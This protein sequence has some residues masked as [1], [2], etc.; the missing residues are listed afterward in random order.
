VNLYDLLCNSQWL[1]VAWGH[2]STNAGS[3]TAGVDHETMTTFNEPPDQKL[4]ALREQRKAGTFEPMPVRRVYIPKA[5]GKQRPL[6]IP[7]IADRIVQEAL[8]MILEPLWEADFSIHSYGFRPNRSTYDAI[9]YMSNH[10][11]GNGRSYQWIIEGD[12]ASY[13]DTI[14]HRRLIKAVNKRVADRE[15]RDLIW[16]FLRAGVMEQGKHRETLT[17]TPQGGIVSPLLANIYLHAL[18]RYMES[19]YLNLSKWKHRQRRGEGKGN[20]LYTRYADDFV[21][22]CNGTRADAQHMKEELGAL[23]S[24]MGLKLS[25]AIRK[26]DSTVRQLLCGLLAIMKGL[27]TTWSESINHKMYMANFDHCSTRFYATFIVLTVPTVPPMPG[28]RPFHHPTFGEGS[29]ACGTLRTRLDLEVPRWAM[30]G[31]PRVEGVIMILLIR[32]DRDQTR[33]IGGQHVPEPRRGDHP[34]IQ[35]GAGHH[36]C[37]QQAEGV[38]QQMALA[39]FDF[40]PAV[41][42]TLRATNLGGLDRLAIDARG[43]WGGLVSRGDAGL[44]SQYLHYCGPGPIITPLGKI[45]IHR[46]LGQQIMRQHIPLTA[47]PMQVKNSVQDFSHVYGARAP[48]AL[49]R[50]GRRDHRF[51]DGPLRVCEIGFI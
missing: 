31:Q 7:S 20:V 6:G 24:T 19:N 29:K 26:S 13:F 16:K 47:T 35:R 23:L 33:K 10:L 9:S 45:V 32:K 30:I 40:F 49:V 38:D 4:A 46:A 5:N 27:M 22:L 28:V 36:H 43:T 1:R 41:I 18:D 17:G 42:P 51:Q 15:I 8:R 37:Q 39:P 44:F 11:T 3:E 2:G 50:L 12:I 34:I 21:V 48:S 25:E 14:P